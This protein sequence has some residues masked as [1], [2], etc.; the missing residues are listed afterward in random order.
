M[1]RDKTSKLLRDMKKGTPTRNIPLG[2]GVEIPDL[3]GI[4]SNQA[5]KKITIG[6]LK[7]DMPSE[8]IPYSDGTN[9]I[10]NAAFTIN[11]TTFEVTIEADHDDT[12]LTLKSNEDGSGS[13]PD[14]VLHRNSDSPT[15]AD[16]IGVV[17]FTAEDTDSNYQEYARL[18]GRIKTPTSGAEDGSLS[19]RITK[20]GT[21]NIN[22][23]EANYN[24][25]VINEDSK[26]IDFRVESDS[27]QYLIKAD[28]GLFGGA[29]AIGFGHAGDDAAFLRVSPA[30]YTATASTST[31]HC[32]IHGSG[33]TIPSG[34]TPIVASLRVKEPIITNNGTINNAATVYIQD[35]PSEGTANY[36]LWVA[37]GST[38]LD[39]GIGLNGLAPVP[40]SPPIQDA[41]G[42][43]VVDTEARA[44]I[45]QLLTYLRQRGDVLP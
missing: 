16:L 2:M 22:A 24:E 15:A 44:A 29:G 17:V 34:T 12:M 18:Q 19:L 41:I 30:A 14:L 28:A 27:N 23:L 42:G 35:A 32:Q 33:I 20:A 10:S 26:D 25:V 13:A 31:A 7:T 39:G 37:G 3:S 1:P 36:A 45:N 11:P 9:L 38:K 6:D 40:I 8:R 5:F 21:F 4:A 43:A